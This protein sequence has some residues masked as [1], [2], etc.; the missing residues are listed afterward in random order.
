MNQ[1]KRLFNN[2]YD[3]FVVI[4]LYDE[5]YFSYKENLSSIQIT[6]KSINL[7]FYDLFKFS[8][9]SVKYRRSGKL[10]SLKE[11]AKFYFDEIPDKLNEF[12][13]KIINSKFL[14]L[15]YFLQFTSIDIKPISSITKPEKINIILSKN[16]LCNIFNYKTKEYTDLDDIVTI[17][18]IPDYLYI[19]LKHSVYSFDSDI[20]EKCLDSAYIEIKNYKPQS[21]ED[22]L[23]KI[24]NI[25]S[26]LIK[27]KLDKLLPVLSDDKYKVDIPNIVLGN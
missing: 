9:S 12:F 1:L 3:S 20:E 7:E 25:Y 27:E 23:N 2:D 15:E 13:N 8:E 6:S 22:F 5:F 14:K 10:F 4:E 19:K 24:K 17:Y 21:F 16:A 11:N 26:L 18:S